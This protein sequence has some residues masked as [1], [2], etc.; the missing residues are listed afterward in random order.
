MQSNR[1]IKNWHWLVHAT[2]QTEP[3]VEQVTS[4][5]EVSAQVTAIVLEVPL[6][7]CLLAS[8]PVMAQVQVQLAGVVTSAVVLLGV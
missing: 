3:L 7:S 1:Y 4:E 2:E 8:Q 5:S 6:G